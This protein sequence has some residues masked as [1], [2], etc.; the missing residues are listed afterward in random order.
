MPI[1][2]SIDID[3]GPE[4]IWSDIASIESHV[5]WMADAVRIDFTTGQRGGTGTE[6]VVATRIGPFRTADRMRFTT[7]DPPHRMGVEHEGLFT[8]A[9]EFTLEAIGPN[10]TRFTWTED[11]RFPWYLGGPIGAFLARPILRWIW[12]GNLRRLR[13]RFSSP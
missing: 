12:V 10:R 8:G 13:N 5:E 1:E 9:G 2:V 6:A 7:W 3:A 11:I 4:S